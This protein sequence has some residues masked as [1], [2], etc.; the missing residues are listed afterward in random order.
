LDV[1]KSIGS[2]AKS[3]LASLEQQIQS[4]EKFKFNKDTT[5]GDLE[6]RFPAVAKE[7]EAE[8]KANK[9]ADSIV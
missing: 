5:V 4:F 8:L 7:V 1:A 3:D 2:E 6:A 9:W